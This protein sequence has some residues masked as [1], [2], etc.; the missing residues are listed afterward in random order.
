MTR[1]CEVYFNPAC[2]KCRAVR[3]I[4][5]QRGIEATYREYLVAPPT[6][7]EIV[8]VMKRLGVSDPR[9]MMRASDG[10]FAELGLDAADADALIDAMVAHPRLIERP[11]V[12]C[13]ARA[14]IARPPE[15]VTELL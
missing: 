9:A 14:V 3:A 8:D 10:L 1:R 11:I 2:S 15:R 4:L 7:A 5:E 13:G 12:S 6:R